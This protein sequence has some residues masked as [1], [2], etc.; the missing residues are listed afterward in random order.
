MSIQRLFFALISLGVFWI[1]VVVIGAVFSA[2][3]ASIDAQKRML[4]LSDNWL[5][6]PLYCFVGWIVEAR[7]LPDRDG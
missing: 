4:A 1:V 6:R 3:F 2:L 5:L 7:R